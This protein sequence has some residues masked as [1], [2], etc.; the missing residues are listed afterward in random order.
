MAETTWVDWGGLE[1]AVPLDELPTFHRAFL[2]LARPGENYADAPLR[3]VQ[4]KVQASLKQL[5]RDGKAKTEGETLLVAKEMI[6]E[7][8]QHYADDR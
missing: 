1:S 8:F 2:E 3:Q 4:G 6:P 7:T 5:E